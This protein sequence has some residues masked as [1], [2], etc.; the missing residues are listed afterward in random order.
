[1]KVNTNYVGMNTFSASFI[2][3]S[4]FKVTIYS[5]KN[6]TTGHN[7]TVMFRYAVEMRSLTVESK[8]RRLYTVAHDFESYMPYIINDHL[9]VPTKHSSGVCMFVCEKFPGHN[10]T[11]TVT[12]LRQI[13]FLHQG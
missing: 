4:T 3:I 7:I 12:N 8:N 11:P 2:I 1:M 5:P 13:L 9:I 10:S 6:G